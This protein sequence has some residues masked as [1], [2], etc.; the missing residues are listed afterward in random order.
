MPF[1]SGYTLR[2][3]ITIDNT[4]VDAS[5]TDFQLL[6]KVTSDADIGA[7]IDA[8][9]LNIR[10]TSSDGETL[11][12]YERTSFSVGG[13]EATGVFWVKVPTISGSVDTDIYIYY[14]S[15]SPSEGADPANVWDSAFKGVWHL[16]ETSGNF[17]DSTANNN[18]LTETGGTV[19]SIAGK[20]HN[21]RDF[22]EADTEYGSIADN[23]A[24]STGD[25][26]F[27]YSGWFK[28]ETITAGGDD[29]LGK[30]G[31]SDLETL[32]ELYDVAGSIHFRWGI[33]SNG[34]SITGDNDNVES[35]VSAGTWTYFS[36]WHD[37]TGNT[38]NY[39]LNDETARSLSYS[40]GGRDGG[41]A[42]TIGYA[43]IVSREFDG[44]LDEI[45]FF[46]SIR[47]DAWRRFE[48]RNM[49]E[50]DNEIG[51]G[52]EEEDGGAVIPRRFQLLGIGA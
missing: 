17:L 51:Y 44:V 33:S 7:N 37:P 10:F 42:F 24:L 8:G 35:A 41:G 13:G 49:F 26:E 45:R 25:I 31:A 27:G 19:D 47:S 22:E 12:K 21:G 14:K 15:A 16:D 2:K 50:A 52:A 30:I 23:A 5:L 11:L 3:K 6:V 18:D 39:K 36:A 4:Y 1:L 34:V 38:L 43:N 9:G 46:K 32:I 40:G 48:Y 20:V 28:P 29:I